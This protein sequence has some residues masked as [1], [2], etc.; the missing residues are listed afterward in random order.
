MLVINPVKINRLDLNELQIY[1]LF[2]SG[3]TTPSQKKL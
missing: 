2:M 3:E 1:I